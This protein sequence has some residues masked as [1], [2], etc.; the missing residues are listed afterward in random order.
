MVSTSTA[1]AFF[2]FEPLG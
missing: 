2:C 1:L